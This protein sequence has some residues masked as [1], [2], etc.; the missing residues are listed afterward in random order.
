MYSY[1][2]K[3]HVKAHLCKF[4]VCLSHQDGTESGQRWPSR[5]PRSLRLC[6]WSYFLA[7][8][9]IALSLLFHISQSL[10]EFW[11]DLFRPPLS[12]PL[13]SNKF[14]FPF[15]YRPT[16]LISLSKHSNICSWFSKNELSNHETCKCQV[17]KGTKNTQNLQLFGNQEVNLI[18][19][20]GCKS[21]S[22]DTPA[23]L[24][25]KLKGFVGDIWSFK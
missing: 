3:T 20:W 9:I 22:G 4:C 5:V 2:Y 8:Y 19:E 17:K 1:K 18:F 25:Q 21:K 13:W 12:I 23:S 15:F 7:I 24:C 6:C 14:N 16:H 11:V 10:F